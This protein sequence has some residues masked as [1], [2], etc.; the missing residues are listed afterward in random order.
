MYNSSTNNQAV[1][2]KQQLFIDSL[3]KNGAPKFVGTTKKEAIAYI[4]RWKGVLTQITEKQLNYIRS[5]EKVTIPFTGTT[6]KEAALYIDKYKDKL[7]DAKFNRIIRSEIRSARRDFFSAI[8]D[9]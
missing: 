6:R 1:T 8:N 9:W 4:K 2:Y 5:I 3:M 7:I